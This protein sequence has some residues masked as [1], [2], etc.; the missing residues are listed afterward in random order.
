MITK[1]LVEKI[2]NCEFCSKKPVF[3]RVIVR[4]KLFFTNV[5][6]YAVCEDCVSKKI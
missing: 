1:D 4:D 2:G 6:V 5:K 3:I